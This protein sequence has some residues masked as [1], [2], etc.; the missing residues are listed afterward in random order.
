MHEVA[1]PHE[2]ETGGR[3][4]EGDDRAD[5][6]YVALRGEPEPESF[7]GVDTE[8]RELAR[9]HVRAADYR[10]VAGRCRGGDRARRR[11][12]RARRSGAGVA[13]PADGTDELV[14]KCRMLAGDALDGL[15]DDRDAPARTLLDALDAATGT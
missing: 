9:A 13:A 12:G 15:L 7:D 1:A 6:E 3:P 14:A 2:G 4:R 8:V 11:G 5:D 10:C